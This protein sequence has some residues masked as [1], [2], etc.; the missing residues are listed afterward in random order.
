MATSYE[1]SETIIQ[2]PLAQEECTKMPEYD[3]PANTD[4]VGST[5]KVSKSTIM[6]VFVSALSCETSSLSPTLSSSWG[7]H[8]LPQLPAACRSLP[9]SSLKLARI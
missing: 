3:L 5:P 1:E 4:E 2:A 9:A 6:A 7:Y 8:T